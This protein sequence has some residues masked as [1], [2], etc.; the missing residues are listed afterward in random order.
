VNGHGR[1]IRGGDVLVDASL[2]SSRAPG[3]PWSG[4][5][6]HFVVIANTAQTAAGPGYT[7]SHPLGS[8][9][10]VEQRGGIAYLSIRNIAPSEVVLLLNRP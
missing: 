7:G 4:K 5:A 1:D 8:E 9:L 10:P 6:P 2:N 3:N